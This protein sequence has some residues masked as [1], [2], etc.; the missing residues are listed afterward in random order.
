MHDTHLPKI[1]KIDAL[2]NGAQTHYKNEN[3][4]EACDEFIVSENQ[5]YTFFKKAKRVSREETHHKLDW[6]PCYAAGTLTFKNQTTA[7]WK[8]RRYQTGTLR[9]ENGKEILLYC[10]NCKEQ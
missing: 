4:D 5:I 7:Q 1:I 6:S 2:E 8:I 10:P 9:F 3:S